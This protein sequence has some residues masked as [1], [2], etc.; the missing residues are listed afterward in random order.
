MYV[1]TRYDVR[2]PDSTATGSSKAS[3]QFS[4][5]YVEIGLA[6]ERER[7]GIAS[8]VEGF[9]YLVAWMCLTFGL[10]GI[11]CNNGPIRL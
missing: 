9:A 1:P 7:G 8:D 4:A 10:S 5:A 2:K 11:H 6:G 3:K